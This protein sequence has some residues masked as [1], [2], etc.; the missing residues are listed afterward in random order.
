MQT[1]PAC[2]ADLSDVSSEAP[3]PQSSRRKSGTQNIV[4]PYAEK[5]SRSRTSK[6][7]SMVDGAGEAES[8]VNDLSLSHVSDE[9]PVLIKRRR[10]GDRLNV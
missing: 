2:S 9:S 7:I 8:Y 4:S 6:H 10:H 1:V 3:S 5:T